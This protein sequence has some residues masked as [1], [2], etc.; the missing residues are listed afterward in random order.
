MGAT[1]RAG[2]VS[3]KGQRTRRAEPRARAPAAAKK[4]SFKDQ[5]DLDR[6]PGEIERIEAEIA[7]A[8]AELHDPTSMRRTPNASLR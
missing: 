8:E 2:A 6:L 7:A 5:R 1:T 3:A 4:L